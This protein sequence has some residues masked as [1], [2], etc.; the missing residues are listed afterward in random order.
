V[1]LKP[2]TRLLRA[3]PRRF[4]ATVAIEARDA[5]GNYRTVTA[6]TRVRP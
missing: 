3:L 6:G 5:F 1:R 4:R 2:G